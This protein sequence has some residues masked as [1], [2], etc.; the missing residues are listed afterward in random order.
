M[1][2]LEKSAETKTARYFLK[3]DLWSYISKGGMHAGELTGVKLSDTPISH[4]NINGTEKS[5]IEKMSDAERARYL[6]ITVL[7]A[8]ND[9]SNYEYT[10]HKDIINWYY[11]HGL[12][13]RQAAI[14]VSLSEQQYKTQ[15]KEALIEF[16]QRFNFW[17]A[18]RNCDDLPILIY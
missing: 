3:H 11:I 8:I 6:A 18:Y 14:K 10:R 7:I 17:R 16:T 13:N 2:E 12:N 9:C 5:Y 1:T 4:S 15:K